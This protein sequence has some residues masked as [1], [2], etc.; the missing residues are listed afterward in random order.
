MSEPADPPQE[1]SLGLDKWVESLK[2]L[3][4]K[5][6]GFDY[7]KFFQDIV[8]FLSIISTPR[9]TQSPTSPFP[10]PTNSRPPS[11]V[12]SRSTCAVRR[13]FSSCCSGSADT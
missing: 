9:P 2:S 11:R 8:T 1:E 12:C 10:S 13:L 6:K 4:K 7:R 5:V 3:S